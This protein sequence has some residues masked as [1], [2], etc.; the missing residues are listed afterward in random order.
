MCTLP[1]KKQ[2]LQAGMLCGLVILL[3][4]CTGNSGN[5]TSTT[6]AASIQ[7]TAVRRTQTTSSATGTLPPGV[8]LGP[9]ACPAAVKDPTYW[10]PIIPTQTGVSKVESVTCGYLKGVPTLQALVTVRYDGTG[11][12]LDAYVYDNLSSATPTQIFKLQNLYKGDAKISG[13]NSVLTAEVDLASSINNNQPNAALTAD[14]CRE[15]KWSDSVDTLVQIAFPG[16]YPDLTRYQAEVDQEQVNQGHQPWKLSATKTAQALGASLLQWDPNATATLVSGGGAKDTQAVVH[17][18]NTAPGGN[19]ITIEM[20]RLEGNADG[21]IWIITSVEADG[22]SITQPQ[23][24]SIIHSST[25]VTGTGSAFEGVIGTVSVLDHLYTTIG[26]A[27]VHGA[28]GNGNTT[29][30]TKITF[31]PTFKNGI[32]EGLILLSAENNAGGPAA[33]AVIAKVLIQQ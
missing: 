2:F 28:T 24:T 8:A 29:F 4:A 31:Q 30:S 11:S 16:I 12:I 18:K 27:T 23:N 26:H 25:T 33:G 7:S 19:G 10:D 6:S 21:G 14:L 3:I 1:I 13:Y 22:M 15:F 17:L 5:G 32:E 9:Q 20:A